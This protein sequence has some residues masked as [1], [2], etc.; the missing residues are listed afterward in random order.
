ML[1]DGTNNY[2]KSLAAAVASYQFGY[3]APVIPVFAC[4]LSA[5]LSLL[6]SQTDLKPS[7]GSLLSNFITIN[8]LT[9]TSAI[10]K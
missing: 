4:L 9:P 5:V 6:C 3:F 7:A 8:N 10:L 2:W 1:F